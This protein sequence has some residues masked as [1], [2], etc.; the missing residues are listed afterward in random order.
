MARRVPNPKDALDSVMETIDTA[1]GRLQKVPQTKARD[2]AIDRCKA[3][4]ERALEA[5]KAIA[6]IRVWN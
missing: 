3:T 4:K 1:I 6:N 2:E 5:R